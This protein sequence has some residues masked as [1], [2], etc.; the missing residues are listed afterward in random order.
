MRSLTLFAALA[1]LAT[2]SALA[3]DMAKVRV[4]H[5]GVAKCSRNKSSF[6]VTTNASSSSSSSSSTS[7][8]AGFDV[9]QV[10]SVAQKLS[11]HSWEYGFL[12]ESLLEYYSP[13]LSVF[14]SDPFPNGKVPKPTVSGVKALTYVKPFISTSGNT[15]A[16]GDGAV[17]DAASLGVSAALIGQSDSTYRSALDR[18]VKH[19][20]T[21][22]RYSNGAISQ[23]EDVAELWA[24]AVY[25]F[26]PTLAYYAV[27]TSNE[28]MLHDAIIQCSRYRLILTPSDTPSNANWTGMWQ[29]IVGPQSQT[30]GIWATGNGWAAMGMTRVLA[31]VMKWSTSSSWTSQQTLLKRWIYAI[32]SGAKSTGTDS[33]GLIR[34]YV[35]GGPSGASQSPPSG[36]FGD[37]TGTA[38][39]ASVAYRMAVLD[40]SGGKQYVS[41]ADGL[42]KAVAASVNSTGY[43]V[44][45]VDPLN[46]FATNPYY[47]GSP[48]GQSAAGVMA[49]AYRDCRNAGR[50]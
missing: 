26:P 41:W 2:T 48:E 39:L 27:L 1:V 20:Y 36:N 35:A 45:T 6:K 19:L 4:H 17:G 13:T 49:A 38:M 28:T 7:N 50:C 46:W 30:L 33:N 37:V 43:A 25:M 8:V 42:R 34:N 44:P 15:L 21:A 5:R 18:Q 29:H 14:G 12:A 32:L 40:P 23:R 9:D 31:T 16:N 22:P 3:A 24:D 11:S 47:G 10:L